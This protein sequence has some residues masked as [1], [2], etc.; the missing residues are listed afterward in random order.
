LTVFLKVVFRKTAFIA[1]GMIVIM[2]ALA[3]AFDALRSPLPPAIVA[4]I[5]VSTGLALVGLLLRTGLLSVIVAIYVF[6]ILV[7]LQLTPDVSAPGVTAS[8]VVLCGLA[9]AACFAFRT[10]LAGR[11]L[12]HLEL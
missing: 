7:S 5:M 2:T 4:V 9:A 1:A 3:I 11:R 12:F 8:L 6:V 10:T